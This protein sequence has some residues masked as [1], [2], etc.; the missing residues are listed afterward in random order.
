M[1]MVPD[2][3]CFRCGK[4]IRDTEKEYCRDCECKKRYFQQG[5]GLYIHEKKAAAAVYRFKFQNQ[6]NFAE[7]FAR[8]LAQHYK[9]Q[10]KNW[11]VEVLIPIPLHRKKQRKRGY[12]QAELLARALSKR[13]G[14]PVETEALLR[15][16]NTVPQKNLHPRMREQ[17]LR[18]AFGVS[19]DW[20]PVKS[21][22]LLDDIYTTGNTINKAAEMLKRAGVGK[23][24][25]LSISIG[26]DL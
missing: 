24:Y 12:N 2:T 4:P 3:V 8:E 26:Q 21:V 17:N 19:K 18:G 10:L 16:R 1:R 14:I 23:V 15:V 6:R 5:R 20:K 7:I 22:L 11:G 9:E 25:F 13:T